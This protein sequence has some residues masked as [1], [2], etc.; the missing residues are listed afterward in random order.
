MSDVL[1]NEAPILA[2]PF[3]TQTFARTHTLMHAHPF[4]ALTIAASMGGV[5]EKEA[6]VS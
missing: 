3:H 6:L 2:F 1:E 4:L 5:L